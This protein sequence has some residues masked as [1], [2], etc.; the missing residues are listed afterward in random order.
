MGSVVIFV[1]GL[2]VLKYVFHTDV[3]QHERERMRHKRALKKRE[4]M[5]S[6]QPI[7]AYRFIYV[8][9]PPLAEHSV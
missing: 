6:K 3:A 2:D 9:R 8:D 5:M 1:V 4:V 7:V